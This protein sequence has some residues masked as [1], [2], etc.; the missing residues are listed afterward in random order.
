MK[1][2]RCLPLASA[3][4]FGDICELQAV[5]IRRLQ[6]LR[7]IPGITSEENSLLHVSARHFLFILHQI[8][9]ILV[10]CQDLC[11]L[12]N[13]LVNQSVGSYCWRE[14]INN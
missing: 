8:S 6:K 9:K 10:F 7:E 4:N 3:R 11:L 5:V 13:N 12:V 2:T 1:T 14:K